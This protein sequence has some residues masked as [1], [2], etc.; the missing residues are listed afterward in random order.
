MVNIAYANGEHADFIRLCD[1]LD[2]HLNRAVGG[3]ENRM[4]YLPFNTREEMHDVLLA[5]ADGR[6]VGCVALRAYAPDTAEV[7]R[8]F[9]DH[10]CRG[11]GIGRMLLHALLELAR[12]QGYAR[13]I[14]ETG[15][16]LPEATALYQSVGF[17]R[18]ANFPPY[19]GMDGSVCMQ[20]L[21]T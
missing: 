12:V 4:Q 2:E 1:A 8:M 17:V 9:V 19:E 14:L 21:L 5:Y 7:K 15:A 3:E 13:V 6:A 18:I 10:A 20:L 11:A 16:E